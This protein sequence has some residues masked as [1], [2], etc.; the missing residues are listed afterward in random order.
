ML[1]VRVNK[2]RDQNIERKQRRDEKLGREK[3]IENSRAKRT[4]LEKLY[5]HHSFYIRCDKMW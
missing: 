2:Q 4:K 1:E 5:L 3:N